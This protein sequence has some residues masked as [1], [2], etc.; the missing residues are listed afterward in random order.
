MRGRTVDIT[1]AQ[2]LM[3]NSNGNDINATAK[4]NEYDTNGGKKREDVS[5]LIYGPDL[6]KWHCS[7]CMDFKLFNTIQC[8]HID[9][10]W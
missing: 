5:A 4:Y 9:N 7:T 1:I 8:D 6:W 3:L 10:Q 2:R